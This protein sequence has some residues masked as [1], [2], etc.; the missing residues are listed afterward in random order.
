MF[1][2]PS[3][4]EVELREKIQDYS[5][6]ADRRLIRLAVHEKINKVVYNKMVQ[7]VR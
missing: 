2:L 6:L 4:L 7:K 1:I 3:P 5:S